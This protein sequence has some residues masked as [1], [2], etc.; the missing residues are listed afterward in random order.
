MII[1][2]HRLTEVFESAISEYLNLEI[3]ELIN[4]NKSSEKKDGLLINDLK[5]YYYENKNKI[6]EVYS[7]KFVEHFFNKKEIDEYKSK[8]TKKNNV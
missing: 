7:S 4:F 3:P 2:T 5:S 8:W 6:S 1:L